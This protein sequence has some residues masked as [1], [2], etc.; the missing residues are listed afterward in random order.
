MRSFLEKMTA[1]TRVFALCIWIHLSLYIFI[2][3]LSAPAAPELEGFPP[4]DSFIPPPPPAPAKYSSQLRGS[5]SY[6]S[7][8]R[9]RTANRYK[10]TKRT[11]DSMIITG[12][13]HHHHHHHN[14]SISSTGTGGMAGAAGVISEG[15]TRSVSSKKKKLLNNKRTVY[16]RAS[17]RKSLENLGLLVRNRCGTAKLQWPSGWFACLFSVS[18]QNIM[19]FYCYE[20]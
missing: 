8:I 16:S 18:T 3:I 5:G 10:I 7:M 4:K 15:N 1:M 9:A 14:T 12:H 19:L 11:S 2:F 6:P 13:H 20:A 17:R